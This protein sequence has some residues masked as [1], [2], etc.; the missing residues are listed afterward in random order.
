MIIQGD[1]I[2]IIAL[3]GKC[4]QNLVQ[5]AVQN[6]EALGYKVKLSKNIYGGATALGQTAMWF[7]TKEDFLKEAKNILCDGDAVLIKA[8]HSRPPYMV[9]TP[10]LP[11]QDI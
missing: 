10:L 4:E 9:Y 5:N 7:E 8:S 11:W 6:L 3:G 2:G 1:T